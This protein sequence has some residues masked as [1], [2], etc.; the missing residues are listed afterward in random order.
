MGES[1]ETERK[2]H[3]FE[4]Y[5]VMKCPEANKLDDKGSLERLRGRSQENNVVRNNAPVP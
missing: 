1:G 2:V 5:R 4:C 3:N